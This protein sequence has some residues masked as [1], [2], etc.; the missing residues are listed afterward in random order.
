M[1]EP[2]PERVGRRKKGYSQHRPTLAVRPEG[3][4]RPSGGDQG[5]RSHTQAGRPGAAD[6]A[7]DGSNSQ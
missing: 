4:M 6:P 2:A 3:N 5:C 7:Q 1:K